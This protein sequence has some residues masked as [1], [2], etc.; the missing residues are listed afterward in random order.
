MQTTYST[1]MFLKSLVAV[2]FLA[3]AGQSLVQA[4]DRSDN[5]SEYIM[6][7]SARTGTSELFVLDLNSSKVSPLT[8]TGRG[9]INPAV[10]GNG[11]LATFAS[12][13]GS[14]YELFTAQLSAT[15]KTRQPVFAE[16]NR[17]TIDSLEQ[18]NPTISADGSLIAFSVDGGIELM[19]A[20]GQNRRSLVSGG[21]FI[22]LSPSISPDG[23]S[24][25]FLSNRDGKNEIWVVETQ[26]GQL[27]QLTKD[28]GVVGGINWSPDSQRIVFTTSATVSKLTGIAIADVATGDFRVATEAGDGE[29][30]F[31]PESARIVFTSNRSGDPELFLL[32]L[33][34]NSVQQLTNNPGP[35]GS[36]VFLSAA[37]GS[38]RRAA[39]SRRVSL[40]GRD[41]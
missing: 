1:R 37:S 34:T 24:V 40:R 30:S 5:G 15:W 19:N 21:N 26:N 8:E 10:A 18:T 22:T 13:E 7:V 41:Q 16:V 31:S 9:H 2:L 36:A 20:D 29:A 32:N 11:R 4:Q 33:N 14:S 17:L 38:V 25:A 6:F 12:R 27:R 23:K 39:P 3:I 35:D 28:A